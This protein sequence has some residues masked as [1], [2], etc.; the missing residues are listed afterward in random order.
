MRRLLPVV[1]LIMVCVPAAFFPLPG[2]TRVE[3]GQPAAQPS[4]QAELQTLEGRWVRLDGGYILA[5]GEVTKVGSVKA[6][7]FNPR[8][9]NVSRAEVRRIA[10]ALAVLVELRDVNYPGSTYTLQYDPATDRLKGAYFQA[11]E[12]QTF[13]VEFVRAK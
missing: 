13:V 3:A 4:R 7:Y 8:P 1:A 5:L 2:T 9:I 10:G 6:S 12:K 11:V